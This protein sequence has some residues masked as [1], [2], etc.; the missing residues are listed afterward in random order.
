MVGNTTI[1]D[2]THHF[3]PTLIMGLIM[4]SGLVSTTL[5]IVVIV[6]VR[7]R[8]ASVQYEQLWL[9]GGTNV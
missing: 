7:R 2:C 5:F 3:N 9:A 4:Y 8:R 6:A 1:I